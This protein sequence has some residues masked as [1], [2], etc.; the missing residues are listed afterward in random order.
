[1][2]PIAQSPTLAQLRLQARNERIP[3]LWKMNK[4]QL[5]RALGKPAPPRPKLLASG[6]KVRSY[7]RSRH[8]MGTCFDLVRFGV[9]SGQEGKTWAD[10]RPQIDQSARLSKQ[11][12]LK[13]ACFNG[14]SQRAANNNRRKAGTQLAASAPIPLVFAQTLYRHPPPTPAPPAPVPKPAPLLPQR[15]P[16]TNLT[17]PAPPAPVPKPAPLLPQR[18]P[19]TNVPKPAPPAPVPM[20]EPVRMNPQLGIPTVPGSGASLS[21]VQN[22]FTSFASKPFKV[23]VAEATENWPMYQK[24]QTALGK[25][26]YSWQVRDGNVWWWMPYDYQGHV[27][28]YHWPKSEG[29]LVGLPLR[30]DPMDGGSNWG[31]PVVLS[32]EKG[33]AFL[34]EKRYWDSARA[35]INKS[36]PDAQP[37][38]EEWKSAVITRVGLEINNEITAKHTNGEPILLR[39]ILYPPPSTNSATETLMY[40]WIFGYGMSLPTQS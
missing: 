6:T 18:A 26:G 14:I 22:Y 35:R 19:P 1:M 28:V 7:L 32:S 27:F 5:M 10:I 37:G 2:P 9:K 16:P 24:V 23:Q 33:N 38:S 8:K 36:F 13:V 12:G 4:A 21:E 29:R 3:G 31:V 20:S 39:P 34:I 40:R 17:K 25:R 15:A 30:F 11:N